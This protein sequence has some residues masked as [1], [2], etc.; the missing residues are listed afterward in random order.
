MT[1]S[2]LLAA[3][4][5]VSIVG[6]R[7]ATHRVVAPG[8]IATEGSWATAAAP[9]AE[10]LSSAVAG[11]EVWV[12]RGRHAGPIRI[13]AGVTVLGGFRGDETAATQ[14][15][16]RLNATELAFAPT[17]S[18]TVVFLPG[19]SVATLDGFRFRGTRNRGTVLAATN[20]VPRLVDVELLLPGNGIGAFPSEPVGVFEFV[21]SDV[22]VDGLRANVATAGEAAL[23]RLRRGG[24]R[25]QDCRLFG[26]FVHPPAAENEYGLVLLENSSPRIERNWFA[27][28]SASHG[29]G[30]S[31][32]GTSAPLIRNNLF[33]DAS[34]SSPNL[35]A[36]ADLSGGSALYADTD[37]SPAFLH[38]TVVV[39][40]GPPI[41]LR[42]LGGRVAHNVFALAD[43]DPMVGSRGQLS[44]NVWTREVSTAAESP[45]PVTGF[46]GNRV[47]PASA[48]VGEPTFGR[49]WFRDVPG[50][51]DSSETDA[52]AGD[53]D[54]LGQ[55]RVQGAAPDPG[56]FEHGPALATAMPRRRFRVSTTGDDFNDGNDPSRPFRTV[57]AALRA[58]AREGGRVE[59]ESGLYPERSLVLGYGVDLAGGFASGSDEPNPDRNRSVLDGGGADTI[60]FH[61]VPTLSAGSRTALQTVSGLTFRRGF[62]TSAGG[63]LR[64]AS[65]RIVGNRFEENRVEGP[66]PR[67]AGVGA[68]SGGGAV[69]VEGGNAWIVGNR[70]E[71]NS[72]AVTVPTGGGSLDARQGSG[73][74]LLLVAA[75]ATVRDN[76]FVAN[77]NRV[78]A[79]TFSGSAVALH[80]SSETTYVENNTF[81]DNQSLGNGSPIA[82]SLPRASVLVYRGVFGTPSRPL[83]ARNNLFAFNHGTVAKEILQNTPLEVSH[84]V[85]FANRDDTFPAG[86][87][88]VV[89]DPGF[90]GPGAFPRLAA[91]SPLRDAGAPD[92]SAEAG[93]TDL[94]GRPRLIGERVDIGAFEFDPVGPTP[95]V[96]VVRVRVD[97]DDAADGLG[98]STAK[99]T[100]Q[101]AVDSLGLGGGEVWVQGGSH[102]G[103]VRSGEGVRL[104]GG[105][106]GA[107][108][109]REERDWG[110]QPTTIAPPPTGLDGGPL[111]LLRGEGVA[112]EFSGFRVVDG[113]G[114]PAGGLSVLGGGRVGETFFLRN[115]A[116]NIA[117]AGTIAGGAIFHSGKGRLRIENAA[118]ATNTSTGITA[119][120]AMAAIAS[121]E[122]SGGLDLRHVTFHANPVPIGGGVLRLPSVPTS[123]IANSL[124]VGTG[125]TSALGTIPVATEASGNLF[126][127]ATAFAG[128][129]TNGWLRAD[130]LFVN[131][132]VGDFRLTAG[133]PARDSAVAAVLPSELRDLAGRLDA[134]GRGDIGALEY[135]P[136]PPAD[137]AVAIDFPSAGSSIVA[138]R[139]TDVFYF[140]D[141]TNRTAV[142]AVLHVDG[143]P[144]ATNTA[145]GARV[146]RW[147]APLVGDHDLMVRVWVDGF[148]PAD[149]APVNVRV[150]VPVGDTP[151]VIGAITVSARGG[152]LVAPVT[153]TVVASVSDTGGILG[154][155]RWTDS[156][157]R[158]VRSGPGLGSATT[159]P[160]E[161]LQAGTHTFRLRVQDRVGQSA[162]TNVTFRV[163]SPSRWTSNFGPDIMLRALNEAGVVAGF[164]R[165]DSVGRIP[166]RIEQGRVIALVAENDGPGE[167]FALN[168]SGTAVGSLR[169]I[170]TLFRDSGPVQLTNIQ[171]AAL[172][173]NASEQVVGTVLLP[174][175]VARP[176][177]WANGTMTLLPIGEGLEGSA[178]GVN[179]AG[180]VVGSVVDRLGRP[181]A[182]A[183]R[184]GVLEWLTTEAVGGAAH[185][186]DPSGVIVGEADEK[187]MVWRNGVQ[188]TLSGGEA[189]GGAFAISADGVIGG[190]LGGAPAL[191]VAG[192]V[193]DPLRGLSGDSRLF[194]GYL[195]VA[196]VNRRGDL[197]A[198]SPTTYRLVQLRAQVPEP[199]LWLARGSA[200]GSLR[201]E[202]G[203]GFQESP[204][205]LESS[206][207]FRAWQPVGTNVLSL[208]VPADAAQ[209]FFRLRRREP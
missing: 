143:V 43:A 148:L 91:N 5:L 113:R 164:R 102:A 105:F 138:L 118:F 67:F 58:A 179:D 95:A 35:P 7:A 132:A 38:N 1:R 162:E 202:A 127:N 81:L 46:Q 209:R 112:T 55:P 69:Y 136:P 142:R 65:L 12:A 56:A 73:G 171:G 92:T 4:I 45:Q 103:F 159:G 134:G 70:F 41:R 131:A 122:G 86:L 85:A 19:T 178:R 3:S 48:F 115:T 90:A 62:S 163:E 68:I 25:I 154:S 175:G 111:I 165:Q 51:V 47:V 186:V 32:L 89:A 9:L 49:A 99:R 153:V 204:D 184:Q 197:L 26:N 116:T 117:G 157:G 71:R 144:V 196:G 200:P 100:I 194:G 29:A 198:G 137:F 37:A 125:N 189:G 76:L 190:Q 158:P 203:M 30:I 207:D 135:F 44:D 174:E 141:N 97:G 2:A 123:V 156:D 188:E 59:V 155:W 74:A 187:P 39:R 147:P 130:P 180:L 88:N 61:S 66:A 6:S 152:V 72:V 20:A 114:R 150:P 201:L 101:A 140:I 15:N 129:P 28:N 96:P 139:A 206:D 173:I 119:G 22:V 64:A 128:S 42:G 133:S 107:E 14:R 17:Q 16:A 121:Q 172:A 191:W 98:W 181:Q 93:R 149:S 94:E 192:E 52:D 108:T 208:E 185:A 23:I 106:T 126:W 151:P 21:D 11:D 183:W 166:I 27:G 170:P 63:A 34:S 168:A 124:F 31:A 78:A 75:S 60:L 79:S 110:L 193:V 146:I 145:A 13:P 169:G 176:F 24:G 87:S 77:T 50:A 195:R 18:P 84:N 8:S 182:V 109:R 167:A 40:Y 120:S 205:F 161:F 104:Y 199:R 53:T 10:V 177:L 33:T 160:M 80:P 82:G 36:T 54:F 57:D 83:V